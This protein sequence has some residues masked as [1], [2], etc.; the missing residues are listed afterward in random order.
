MRNL[1]EWW[2]MQKQQQTAQCGRS[3]REKIEVI[4]N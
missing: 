3:E 2:V 1:S 4:E